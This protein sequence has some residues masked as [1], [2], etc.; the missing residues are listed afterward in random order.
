MEMSHETLQWML[1][2]LIRNL[3]VISQSQIFRQNSH[4]SDDLSLTVI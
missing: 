4:D 2:E 1:Y 3:Q